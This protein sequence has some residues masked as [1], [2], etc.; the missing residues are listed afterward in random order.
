M[1]Q[2]KANWMAYQSDVATFWLTS[3]NRAKRKEVCMIKTV[4]PSISYA[5]ST[6]DLKSQRCR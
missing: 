3:L 6:A 2:V 1:F 5:L 4:L